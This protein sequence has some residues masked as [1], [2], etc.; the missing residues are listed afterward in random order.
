M[1]HEADDLL[2]LMISHCITRRPE[3][4]LT[5][6][7]L[8]EWSNNVDFPV[9]VRAFGRLTSAGIRWIPCMGNHDYYP[10]SA[11]STLINDY[12]PS[13]SWLTGAYQSGKLENTYTLVTLSGKQWLVLSLEWA[14]R[15]A[16][17]AWSKVVI[18]AH[19][20]IPVILLTHAYLHHQVMRLNWSAGQVDNN[21][22]PHDPALS[23]TP[24][25]GIS[26]GEDLWANLVRDTSAIRLVLCGH[27]APYPYGEAAAGVA[28]ETRS[29]GSVVHQIVQ[30]YQNCTPRGG[31]WL[32]E[33]EFDEGN[34]QLIL[35]TYSP[36]EQRCR[37][38]HSN[39]T[40]L[41]MP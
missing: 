35:S 6:G 3:I 12:F 28:T 20:G 8:V 29:D 32:V 37:F 33:Y 21:Q 9:L 15:T 13:V 7:D 40:V 5:V 34:H 36:Y 16:V 19:P 1:T 25:E 39:S 4:V 11:R 10:L 18:A 27:V 24:A 30:N 41:A 38:L 31:G 2:G 23:A 17:I 14:P 22:N 26:D